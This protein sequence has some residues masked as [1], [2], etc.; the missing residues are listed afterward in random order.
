MNDAEAIDILIVAAKSRLEQL[1]GAEVTRDSVDEGW[2][3]RVA[4][5]HFE[6][7]EED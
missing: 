5:G 3:L 2:N 6:P 4:I 1:R 7:G